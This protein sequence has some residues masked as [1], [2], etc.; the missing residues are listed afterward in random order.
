[1]TAKVIAQIFGYAG[2]KGA[3]LMPNFSLPLEHGDRT[4]APTPVRFA[5][6]AEYLNAIQTK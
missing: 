5:A 3:D 4:E 2:M 1:M 6:L